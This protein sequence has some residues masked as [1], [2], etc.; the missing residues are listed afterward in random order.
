MQE[1]GIHPFVQLTGIL[2]NQEMASLF[3]D[4]RGSVL[5]QPQFAADQTK[6]AALEPPAR[7]KVGFGPRSWLAPK[8]LAARLRCTAACWPP[9]SSASQSEHDL[10]LQAT[11]WRACGPSWRAAVVSRAP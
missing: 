5:A 6:A 3:V 9:S 10:R 8:L 11:T 2:P 1:R 4:L 7:H